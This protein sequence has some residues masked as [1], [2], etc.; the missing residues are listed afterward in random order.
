MNKKFLISWAVKFVAWMAGSFVI[1]GVL[2]SQGY[3]AL[4]GI[5]RPEEE[6]AGYFHFMLIAHVILAGA[7]VWI[8]N[9]G[10]EDKPW[11]QQGI[12]FGIAV[13]LLAAIPVYMIYYVV[14]PT[15]GALAVKQA[16][17]DSALTVVLGLLVAFINKPTGVA[18]E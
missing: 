3:E 17:F 13:A 9:R 11:M 10:S 5:F 4:A 14:Q 8:Y 18:T 12:R 2:L 16:L 6:A 7:F 15:A 1:H